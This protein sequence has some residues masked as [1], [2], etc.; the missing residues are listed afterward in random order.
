LLSIVIGAS[1]SRQRAEKSAFAQNPIVNFIVTNNGRALLIRLILR[2]ARSAAS[3]R[4]GGHRSGLMVRD[5]RI[6]AKHAQAA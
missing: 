2:A 4:M 5:A 3:R 6:A 1:R